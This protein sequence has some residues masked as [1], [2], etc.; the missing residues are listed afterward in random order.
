MAR[1]KANSN[2]ASTN[3]SPVH[4]M[5]NASTDLL[6]RVIQLG[7]K[8]SISADNLHT[9]GRA[10]TTS[11][12]K[13]TLKPDGSTLLERVINLGKN[14]QA[15]SH[16]QID[17]LT[18]NTLKPPDQY[19]G[20]KPSLSCNDLPTMDDD[21][22]S[23][24]RTSSPHDS[25]S[26]NVRPNQGYVNNSSSGWGILKG[27]TN[28][29]KGS[30]YQVVRTDDHEAKVGS[31]DP[32][33]TGTPI[34]C[35][36]IAVIVN[37]EESDLEMTPG[38]PDHVRTPLLAKSPPEDVE[39]QI[40]VNSSPPCSTKYAQGYEQLSSSD[41]CNF[42]KSVI[43][44]ETEMASNIAPW[45]RKAIAKMRDHTNSS[46]SASTNAERSLSFENPSYADVTSGDK[47]S[48]AEV[49]PSAAGL[50]KTAHSESTLQQRPS[51]LPICPS[52]NNVMSTTATTPGDVHDDKE[53]CGNPKLQASDPPHPFSTTVAKSTRLILF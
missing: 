38:S 43:S 16:N 22:G 14:D 37:T 25:P 47:E 41:D 45:K 17:R 13:S 9:I 23:E 33:D 42:Q 39:S 30:G 27:S 12:Y 5:M 8:Q 44:D 53:L 31:E 29:D 20:G 35:D 46:S 28:G 4:Q 2:P 7:R 48:M 15:R 6:Q 36:Q 32:K 34:S 1:R 51:T 18:S 50:L 11:D 10:L 24:S 52:N 49:K 19:R 3:C 40:R 26:N 21:D